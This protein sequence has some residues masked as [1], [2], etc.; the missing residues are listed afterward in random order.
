MSYKI[1][2]PLD[3]STESESALHY[4]QMLAAKTEVSLELVRCFGRPSTVYMLPV[5]E[6][7]DSE[8]MAELNLEQR[9]LGYLEQKK[10][11]MAGVSCEVSV[12]HGQAASEILARAEAADLVLMAP[13]GQRDRPLAARRSHHEGGEGLPHT[14]VGGAGL[15][16]GPAQIGDHHG[17]C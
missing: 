11:E 2:V 12:A 10:G 15:A 14:S 16:G 5:L 1:L 17:V 13:R 7:L 3:G 8:V 9:M 4:V 6:K